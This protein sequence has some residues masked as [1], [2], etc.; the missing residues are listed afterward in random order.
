MGKVI[1]IDMN[2]KIC[3]LCG[4][5]IKQNSLY[6]SLP[7]TDKIIIK[8][9]AGCNESDLSSNISCLQCVK[10]KLLNVARTCE[11]YELYYDLKAILKDD[12]M[13]IV[14]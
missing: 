9:N 14:G 10:Y 3:S 2:L 7:I 1:G 13:N 5:E 12:E 6:V 11:D 8:R 4:K